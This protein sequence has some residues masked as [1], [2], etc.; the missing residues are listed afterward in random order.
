MPTASRLGV[1]HVNRVWVH[2]W[3]AETL[4]FD[5]AHHPATVD[6]GMEP[7]DAIVD[8]PC[9]LGGEVPDPCGCEA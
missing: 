7:R 9:C 6:E 3:G 5:G 8:L 2:S 4:V 1:R